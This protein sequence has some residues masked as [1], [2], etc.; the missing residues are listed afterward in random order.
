MNIIMFFLSIIIIGCGSN[1]SDK[2]GYNISGTGLVPEK[3]KCYDSSWVV[4]KGEAWE[5]EIDTLNC[6]TGKYEWDW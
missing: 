5:R 1:F 4:K 6:R 3:E 2:G